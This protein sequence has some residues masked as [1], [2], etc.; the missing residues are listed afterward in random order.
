MIYHD[1]FDFATTDRTTFGDAKFEGKIIAYNNGIT[2][3]N[4]T[5]QLVDTENQP[6]GTPAPYRIFTKAT[7]IGIFRGG[8]FTKYI[9]SAFGYASKHHS[10]VHVNTLMLTHYIG[11]K[12]LLYLKAFQHTH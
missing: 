9:T 8:K 2:D 12:Y 11:A 7:S 6:T 10:Q 3:N 1:A 5:I 4:G